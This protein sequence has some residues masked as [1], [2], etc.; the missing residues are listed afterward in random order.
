VELIAVEVIYAL[1]DEQLPMRLELPAGASVRQ[2]IESSG[3][4]RKYPQIDLATAKLGIFTRPCKLDD[5]LRD[6]DRVEIYRPL[7]IDPKDARRQRAK[8]QPG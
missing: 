7:L 1:P 2:A 4:L 8:R 6:G 3:V 5:P